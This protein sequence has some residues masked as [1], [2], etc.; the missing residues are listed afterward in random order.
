MPVRM[1]GGEGSGCC[2]LVFVSCSGPGV[3]RFLT[4]SPTS[5]L[6]MR[7]LHWLCDPAKEGTVAQRVTV[8][9]TDDID[10]TEAAETIAAGLSR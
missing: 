7:P 9:M 8:E 4:A 1:T 5:F 3:C 10:G 2:Y 6:I